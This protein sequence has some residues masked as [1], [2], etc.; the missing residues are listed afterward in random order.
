MNCVT[1]IKTRAVTGSEVIKPRFT[2]KFCIAALSLQIYIMNLNQGYNTARTIIDG[3]ALN[4]E[5]DH[6]YESKSRMQL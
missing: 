5:I 1:K 4:K 6:L 2:D 3:A